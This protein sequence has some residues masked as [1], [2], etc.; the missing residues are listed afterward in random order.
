MCVSRWTP[1]RLKARQGCA[2]WAR[3]SS[4]RGSTGSPRTRRGSPRTGLR[5]LPVRPEPVEGPAWF[6]RLTTN[7]R[8]GVHRERD[9]APYPFALSLSK[10]R[11]GSTGSPRTGAGSPRT[12][13]G[14]PRTGL[15]PLP[16]RPEPVEGPAWFDRLEPQ[17]HHG[18]MPQAHHERGG[19]HRE[20][21]YAPYPF[22][23]SL[24]KGRR[25]STGSPR[26]GACHRL[27]TNE[28]G[29]TANGTTPPTRS[30]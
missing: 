22:A 29:F 15:R 23:L 2:P 4:G 5:P 12:R 16:V 17:A 14:S 8:G 25:G 10:G 27:T 9:Y 30:P 26:T 19:V 20:R 1:Q 13:R 11:R 24:S 18:G 3:E 21:D 6:D 7:E 28:E